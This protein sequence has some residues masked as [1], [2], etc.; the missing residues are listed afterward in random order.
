[1]QYKSILKKLFIAV[2]VAVCAFSEK[3]IEAKTLMGGLMAEGMLVSQPERFS[4]PCP[5]SKKPEKQ[6]SVELFGTLGPGI[7]KAGLVKTY[8]IKV[9]KKLKASDW[10]NISEKNKDVLNKSTKCLIRPVIGRVSSGF[11]R[12]RHPTKNVWHFHAGI[13]IVARKGTPIMAAMAGKVVFSGWKRGYGLV[14]IIDHGDGFETVYAHCSRS[15]VKTGQVVNTGQRIAKVG[16]TGV[17]T[18]AHLHFEVRRNG[19][20]R[21]PFRYLKN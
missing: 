16:N 10:K 13:D 5:N 7:S 6:Q 20:V 3:A 11:G 21:N 15:L 12:R 4:L 9:V 2:L 1:M 14:V 8:S 17:A 18:G 19:N